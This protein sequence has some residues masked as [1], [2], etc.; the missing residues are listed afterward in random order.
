MALPVAG[1]AEIER[2]IQLLGAA[3]GARP[4]RRG[5]GV[6]TDKKRESL[7]TAVAGRAAW[8]SNKDPGLHDC[9]Q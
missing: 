1:P 7:M 6:A 3:C 4:S 2:M 8:R 9:G 5:G